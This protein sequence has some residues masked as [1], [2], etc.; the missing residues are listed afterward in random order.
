MEIIDYKKIEINDIKFE[1]PVK[2]KGGSYMAIAKYNDNPIYIQ[3]PRLIN[4]KGFVKNDNRCYIDLEFDKTHWNFYEFITNIDDHNIIKIQKNSESWFSKEFPLD[5]VEDFYKTPIRLGKQ[6]KPPTFKIKVP[7]LKGDMVCSI[8]NSNNNLLTYKDVKT[9]SKIISILHF[10]GL[11]FLKQQVICEWIPI[12]FKVYQK[13]FDNIYLINDNLL[14]DNEQGK[15]EKYIDTEI[16]TSIFPDNEEFE[17]NKSNDVESNS[18]ESN[19]NNN[20]ESND[21]ESNNLESNENNSVESN[22]VENNSV[23]SNIENNENN[24][25]IENNMNLTKPDILDEDIKNL[26]KNKNERIE[27]LE[28]KL[29]LLFNF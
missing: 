2:I 13:G 20:L 27:F 7:I 21:V 15:G 6:S 3:S 18:V 19:E 4:N 12:Q 1:D 28:T 24:L 17:I 9:G 29:K 11:R 23:E 10:Q 5:I 14:S 8:Y 22:D 16:N 26:I 25:S